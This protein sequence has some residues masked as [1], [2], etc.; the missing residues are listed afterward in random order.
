MVFRIKIQICTTITSNEAAPGLKTISNFVAL[1]QR[2]G[3]VGLNMHLSKI[4]ITDAIEFKLGWLNQVDSKWIRYVSQRDLLGKELV[5]A[6]ERR[7]C[8]EE[9][10]IM[11][12]EENLWERMKLGVTDMANSGGPQGDYVIAVLLLKHVQSCNMLPMCF[13]LL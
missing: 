3:K 5:A 10:W 2:S 11:P 9:L 6:S 7:S 1:N 12:M 8:G 13:R 4:P